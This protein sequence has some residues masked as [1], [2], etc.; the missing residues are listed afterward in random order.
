MGKL[1]TDIVYSLLFAMLAPAETGNETDSF[2]VSLWDGGNCEGKRFRYIPLLEDTC[3]NLKQ[4]NAKSMG[5][6]VSKTAK[7]SLYKYE[8]YCNDAPKFYDNHFTLHQGEENCHHTHL[9]DFRANDK[10][11][12]V[13]AIRAK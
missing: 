4:P 1:A 10:D 11:F 2:I 13:K 9:K 12:H 6:R 5:F 8:S 7:M 3:C